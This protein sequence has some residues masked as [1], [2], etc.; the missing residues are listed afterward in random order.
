MESYTQSGKDVEHKLTF[1]MISKHMAEKNVNYDYLSGIYDRNGVY[2]NYAY[3]IS[4]Q[5]PWHIIYEDEETV[6]VF[7]GP[8]PVQVEDCLQFISERNPRLTV[9]TYPTNRKKFP[10]VAIREAV[11]NAAMHFDSNLERDI[12]ITV[13]KK[14]MRIE[15]PGGSYPSNKYG[16]FTPRNYELS[17]LFQVLKLA[18]LKFRGISAITDSYAHSGKKP[19][20]KNADGCFIA[21]LPSVEPL[22]NESGRKL[23][24]E[25]LR[26][27]HSA[28]LVSI[29]NVLFISAHTLKKILT[30]MI[31]NG[32]IF[33]MG[34]G[35][36]RIVFLMDPK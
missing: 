21:S 6:N 1:T 35:Q 5:C 28:L 20:F 15:S 27:H 4:D 19:A 33:T 3:L 11:V 7:D 24:C 23:V 12:E 13:S 14:V 26:V 16:T 31:A 9:T 32:E 29:T 17:K 34:V 8:M 22:D 2:S 10:T 25:F 36:H 30:L 18:K